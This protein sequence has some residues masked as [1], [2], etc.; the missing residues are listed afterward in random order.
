MTTHYAL[1]CG[2]CGRDMLEE[3]PEPLNDPGEL[4]AF[5]SV[6]CS[7]K[8]GKEMLQVLVDAGGI[9]VDLPCGCFVVVHG[10]EGRG[11][12]TPWIVC[13]AAGNFYDWAEHSATIHVEAVRIVRERN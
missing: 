9:M 2:F 12:T 11:S 6:E 10:V 13:E 1:S 4:P 7:R 3:R 8:R 5:C